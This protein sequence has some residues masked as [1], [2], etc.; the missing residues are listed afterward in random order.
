MIS[1]ALK[2]QAKSSPPGGHLLL[3]NSGVYN[4]PLGGKILIDTFEN[5]LKININNIYNLI[6]THW[7]Y[8]T[9]ITNKE[10]PFFD[11][12]MINF[13][14]NQ[15]GKVEKLHLFEMEYLKEKVD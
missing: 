14:I 1:D 3:L 15:E 9:F 4:N 6:G 2:C 12:S 8:N 13:I 11:G 5:Q 10:E 7:H